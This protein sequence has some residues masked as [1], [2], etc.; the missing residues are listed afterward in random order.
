MN[1]TATVNIFFRL[2]VSSS[3]G[4]VDNLNETAALLTEGG[5][6]CFCGGSGE[7]PQIVGWV[8]EQS[9]QSLATLNTRGSLSVK[10]RPTTFTL[11]HLLTINRRKRLN[12]S[13]KKSWL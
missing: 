2:R 7:D 11:H 12:Q 6:F 8:K 5:R 10:I 4:C 1:P 3:G 9:A 13:R